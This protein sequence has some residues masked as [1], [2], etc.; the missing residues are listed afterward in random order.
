MH[1]LKHL[2]TRMR[3]LKHL[4]IHVRTFKH[5]K[6]HV[7]TCPIYPCG[8]CV[9]FPRA[10]LK[11]SKSMVFIIGSN[12]YIDAVYMS[13]EISNFD[14]THYVRTMRRNKESHAYSM[15]ALTFVR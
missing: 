11:I 2:Q 14:N 6:T 5:L 15:K 1:T 4:L 10:S 9:P 13:M 8:V 12:P 7:S 3:T